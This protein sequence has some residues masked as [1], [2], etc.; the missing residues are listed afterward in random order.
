MMMMMMMI[1]EKPTD[2][3][4]GWCVTSSLSAERSVYTAALRW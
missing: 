1:T 3:T 2:K 4:S